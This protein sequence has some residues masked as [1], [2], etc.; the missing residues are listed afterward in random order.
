M[1]PRTLYADTPIWNQLSTEN[2]DPSRFLARLRD[3]GAL[4]VLGVEVISEL[5]A[6]FQSS[7]P[8]KVQLA[9]TYF[10]YLAR[11][12]ESG[13][14]CLKTHCQLLREEAMTIT[15]RVQGFDTGLSA[16]DYARVAS[17]VRELA[18][19]VISTSDRSFLA[20]RESLRN[21]TRVEAVE[22]AR[23]SRKSREMDSAEL[24]FEEFQNYVAPIEIWKLLRNH[25]HNEFPQTPL[26]TLNEVAAALL[27]NSTYRVANAMV[28]ADVYTTWRA[29]RAA[30]LSRDV[31]PDCFHLVNA[32]YCDL[33]ITKDRQQA[34]YAPIILRSADV[35]FY[36]GM[37]PISEWLLAV[38][39]S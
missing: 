36:D 30:A 35:H 18:D 33:Y 37:T 8:Q 12:L 9:P 10:S 26:A 39:S 16:A 24:L 1:I 3:K 25:L 28:R 38:A 23:E 17:K 5:A 6:T 27:R 22:L 29:I 20:E 7:K 21:N 32:S 2:V 15:G 14:P 13:I 11:C 19:G 4:L 34:K 31:M